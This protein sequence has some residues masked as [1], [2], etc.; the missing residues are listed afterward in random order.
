MGGRGRYREEKI[1]EVTPPTLKRRKGAYIPPH[2]RRKRSGPHSEGSQ[3]RSPGARSP[4]LQD[5]NQVPSREAGP[6]G[7]WLLGEGRSER[8]WTPRPCPALC[9]FGEGQGKGRPPRPSPHPI[10]TPLLPP[11]LSSS[12]GPLMG[13]SEAGVRA[14]SLKYWFCLKGGRLDGQAG[15]WRSLAA[16][17]AEVA[18]EQK[19]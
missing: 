7:W 6:R 2:P 14:Q 9:F 8:G 1:N 17:G 10:P 15:G 19:S 18:V 12:D 5:P 13:A 3:V 11:L 4:T 16:P